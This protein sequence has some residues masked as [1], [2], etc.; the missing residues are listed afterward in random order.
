MRANSEPITGSYDVVVVGGGPAGAAA[1]IGLADKGF[2]VALLDRPA[3]NSP[4]IRLGET[5]PPHSRLVLQRLGLW[6]SFCDGGHL[7]SMGIIS[8]WGSDTPSENDFLFNPHGCGWH[9]DREQF[10]ACL[11]AQAEHRGVRVLRGTRVQTCALE[12]TGQV[13]VRLAAGAGTLAA[14]FVVDATGRAGAVRRALSRAGTIT[15]DSLVGLVCNLSVTADAFSMRALI[16]ATERGWWY[17]APLPGGG[18]AAIFMTDADFVSGF[19]AEAVWHEALSGAPATAGRL[20]RVTKSFLDMALRV[21]SASSFIGRELGGDCWAA[22]GDAAMGWDP[23]SSQGICKALESGL[24][25]ANAYER[26]AG[27]DSSALQ[28]FFADTNE[29]FSQYAELRGSYY[30][31]ETRWQDSTFWRRRLMP[32]LNRRLRD[33]RSVN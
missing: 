33:V 20:E 6:E 25:L 32:S 14:G 28:R 8:Y 19:S 27:G 23:L 13:R 9:V 15:I 21:V 29:A 17:S 30:A 5:M 3:T 10:D 16:E 2:A 26:F 7:P 4:R 24:S 22:V 1:A 11:L 31:E 18:L 12:D